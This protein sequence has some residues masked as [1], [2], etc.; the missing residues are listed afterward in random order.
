MHLH[1]GRVVQ[2]AE[3][4]M[5]QLGALIVVVNRAESARLAAAASVAHIHTELSLQV[6]F[7]VG[8]LS[9]VLLIWTRV[10]AHPTVAPADVSTEI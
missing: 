8:L 5:Q 6:R 7:K 9:A 1:E 3:L 4:R 2:A 10:D